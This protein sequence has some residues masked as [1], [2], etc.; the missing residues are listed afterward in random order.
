MRVGGNGS[1]IVGA[2]RLALAIYTDGNLT[3]KKHGV[4]LQC[5]HKCGNGDAPTF[6]VN[7]RHEY[8]GTQKQNERDKK[9]KARRDLDAAIATM[10]VA[11][12][13]LRTPTRASVA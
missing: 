3:K 6:C 1:R 7:P 10:V 2:D 4:L 8:W 5:C 9:R 13:S 12:A 11:K